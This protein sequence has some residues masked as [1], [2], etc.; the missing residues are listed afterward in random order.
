MNT[1]NDQVKKLKI[2]VTTINSY[3]VNSN[4]T[5]K[6]IDLNRESLNEKISSETKRNTKEK[7]L[8]SPVSGISKLTQKATSAIFSGPLSFFDKIKEFF[9]ILLLGFLVKNLP[10]IIGTIERFFEKNKWIFNSLGFILDIIGKGLS[11]LFSL[12][13]K[14]FFSDITSVEKDQKKIDETFRTLNKE[15]DDSQKSVDNDLKQIEKE[16]KKSQSS[17]DNVPT[18]KLAKT[19]P[20]PTKTSNQEQSAQKPSEKQS[21][22]PSTGKPEVKVPKYAKGGLVENPKESSKKMVASKPSSIGDR[23]SVTSKK[24]VQTTN[25][26]KF[27]H[28]NNQNAEEIAKTNTKNN[29]KFKESLKSLETIQEIQRLIDDDSVRD[30]LPSTPPGSQP[31]E[32]LEYTVS[33]GDLPSAYPGR[34]APGH[35]YPGRDYQIPVGKAITVFKPGKVSYAALHSSGYGNLVV[36]DHNDGSKSYYAHLSKINVNVGDEIKENEKVVV[37]LTGGE[38]GAP[39]AGN[40][41]G[42]HLHFEVRK[43]GRQVTNYDDGD[44]YFRFG[45]VTGVKKKSKDEIDRLRQAQDPPQINGVLDKTNKKLSLPQV[46]KLLRDSGASETEVQY[47]SAIAFKENADGSTGKVRDRPDTGDLSYG[48][49]Q[50]NMIDTLGPARLKQFGIKSN[51]DL[52][53]PRV[54]ARAAIILLRSSGQNTWRNSRKKLTQKDLQQVRDEMDKNK[55]SSISPIEKKVLVPEEETELAYAYYQPIILNN[56]THTPTPILIPGATKMYPV[57]NGTSKSGLWEIA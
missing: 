9:G 48:L 16:N 22:I 56:T 43:N 51:D 21:S 13:D 19:S 20:E 31:S 3:L 32:I 12:V 8:E 42:P 45:T 29:E 17:E 57:P 41:T 38:A 23:S 33:G 27:F 40:S 24:A 39:G 15:L 14:V 5:L 18:P 4:K 1:L 35:G 54:N 53:D 28:N 37:G 50:I 6:K 11:G 2:N 10:E 25:Y 49:W 30:D 55:T 44:A 52:L 34:G 47:L 7:K 46:I 26:F 36:I